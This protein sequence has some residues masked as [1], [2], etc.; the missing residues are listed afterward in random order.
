VLILLV[1]GEDRIKGSSLYHGEG[2]F[3]G[4]EDE[5]IKIQKR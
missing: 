2:G 4:E 3:G 5:E 1:R